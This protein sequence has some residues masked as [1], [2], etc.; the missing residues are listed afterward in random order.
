METVRR[1]STKG[2]QVIASCEEGE[3][4]F[5][6]TRRDHRKLKR[7]HNKAVAAAKAGLADTETLSRFIAQNEIKHQLEKILSGSEAVQNAYKVG[8]QF[9]ERM[10]GFDADEEADA[11]ADGD[12]D[13]DDR[14]AGTAPGVGSG[15]EGSP[16]SS[17]RGI[18]SRVWASFGSLL[19][20]TGS[21][22]GKSDRGNG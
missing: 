11:D 1:N 21:S 13:E 22:Q 4:S 19:S 17:G 12:E 14:H 9:L 8:E 16:V 10:K 15:S 5:T 20:P 2:S 3:D 6:Y 18:G 7:I